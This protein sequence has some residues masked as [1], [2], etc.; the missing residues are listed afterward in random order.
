[1]ANST[2]SVFSRAMRR[3]AKIANL[4]DPESVKEALAKLDIAENT[5]VSYCVAYAAFLKFLGKTWK[6]PKYTYRQ[7][8]PEFIP[9]EEEIDQLIAGVGRKVAALL[10]LMKETGFRFGECLSL[11]GTAINFQ[12]NMVTLTIAEKRSLPRVFK[13]SSKLISMLANLPKQNEK[14]FGTMSRQTATTCLLRGRKRVAQKVAGPR[15]GKIHYHLIRHWKGTMEYHKTH[16]PDHVR[17]LL[18]HK[19]LM[20]TQIYINMEQ[21]LFSDNNQEFHVK[22][23]ENLEEACKL[24]EVGFDYVTDI[25]GK[26]LFR[27]RK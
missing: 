25:D 9:T 6:P 14:V 4:N 24:L 1:M 11:Q 18:G 8:L 16:D 2:V 27:K 3:I 7:T 13:V 20:S 26:K 21:A 17:R 5:K 15:I 23:A 19:S 10:Q 12:N 22:V